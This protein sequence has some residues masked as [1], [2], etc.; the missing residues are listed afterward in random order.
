MQANGTNDAEIIAL[1]ALAAALEDQR[2]AE[3]FL[4][5]T[6]LTAPE[7]RQRA[8]ERWLLAAVLEFLENHEPDLLAIAGAIGRRPGDLVAAR[9]ALAE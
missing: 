7:L 9:R 1:Q 2:V 3:R 4:S 5:L 6:G 8:D